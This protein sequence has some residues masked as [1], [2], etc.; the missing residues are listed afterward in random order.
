MPP[1]TISVRNQ[2]VASIV[3]FLSLLASAR[4]EA[5]APL[6]LAAACQET[7]K[8]IA[9]PSVGVSP[10]QFAKLQ[11]TATIVCFWE[12]GMPKIPLAPALLAQASAQK[13]AATIQAG[14]PT[15]TNGTT[16]AVSKPFTPL[17]LATEY[18][19]ITS[20]TNNQTV[21][22]Q[23]TL[24]GIPAAFTTTGRAG[25]C[26]SPI[27]TIPGCVSASRLEWL[28]RVGFGVT[29]NT[30]SSSQNVSGT[31]APSSTTAQP[32][33]LT[34][35]G[36]SSPSFASAFGKI[37]LIRG[38]YQPGTGIDKTLS[39]DAS[40]VNHALQKINIAIGEI[41][42]NTSFDDWSACVERQ[43]TPD[44][45]RSQEDQQRQFAKYWAQIITV[46]FGGQS[47]VCDDTAPV[48][49]QKQMN[50]L[51]P[52]KAKIEAWSKEATGPN[53]ARYDL[54]EAVNNYLAVVDLYE[55]YVD[56]LLRNA[57]SALS[58]E[59][60][61]N[62]PVNQPTTSSVRLLY[63]YAG[64]NSQCPGKQPAE[65]KNEK[66]IPILD[67]LTSTVNIGGNF[68]N[69]TPSAVRGAGALRALQVGTE[70]DYAICNSS[71]QPFWSFF[72]NGTAALTYY[73]QDQV[74]PSILKVATAGMPLPGINIVGLSAAATQVFAK[75]GPI[76]FIQLRYGFG[77]GKN[78]KFPIAVS[79]SNRTDLIAHA[80][81]SAQFGVSYDFSSFL[82]SSSGNS[83]Q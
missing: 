49:T 30:T 17:S 66:E 64:K 83:G 65:A 58:F 71:K 41:E 32:A 26:W 53:K 51:V 39:Q 25:Y 44:H 3:F 67:K 54:V 11:T 21:T 82:N 37:N 15:G 9:S 31:A 8:E 59:Y 24:D 46:V 23:S 55:A 27:V 74:S 33:S 80:T 76:N 22:L 61:Y 12:L 63:S 5:Q 52:T 16:S 18:G 45:L 28:N 77:V 34:N 20:S 14:A 36:N 43:F 1:R 57:K 68:Y 62:T 75:K 40:A 29:A 73:Y 78:V 19:G 7:M 79:W 50:D 69:S 2:R 42:A 13:R 72:G 47:V 10:D 35:A 81:W 48:I 6:K 38:T 70:F 4:M 56:E 60:D